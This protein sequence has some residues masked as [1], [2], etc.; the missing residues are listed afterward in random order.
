VFARAIPQQIYCSAKCCHRVVG[1]N[2]HRKRH[3]E[4][5]RTWRVAA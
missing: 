4:W 5:K 3:P 2:Y 1:R